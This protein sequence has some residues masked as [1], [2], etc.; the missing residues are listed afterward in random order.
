L[1]RATNANSFPSTLR[2][3]SSLTDST[4]TETV[5]VPGT[6]VACVSNLREQPAE[7][8]VLFEVPFDDVELF[9][10]VGFDFEGEE[11]SGVLVM[12]RDSV[13]PTVLGDV[14]VVDGVVGVLVRDGEDYPGS[15]ADCEGGGFVKG[16]GPLDSLFCGAVGPAVYEEF[17][18]VLVEMW[19][20]F[21]V[22]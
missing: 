12:E 16:A 2:V 13:E 7:G 14:E 9:F 6:F 19:D 8:L 20:E 21:F 22:P 17:K 10:G 11:L 15:H 5:T 1:Q 18:V 4:N 3:F